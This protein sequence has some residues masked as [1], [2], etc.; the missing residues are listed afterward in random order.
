M[1]NP[2]QGMVEPNNPNI[3]LIKVRPIEAEYWDA[4]GNLL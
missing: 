3:R 1:G 2:S 4:P